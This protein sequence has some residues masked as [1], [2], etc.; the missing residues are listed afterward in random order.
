[1]ASSKRRSA[2]RVELTP[3]F[4]DRALALSVGKPKKFNADGLPVVRN[5]PLLV[6]LPEGETE[7]TFL[8]VSSAV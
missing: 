8:S 6:K 5:L 3:F 7:F 2:Y 1:M 4:A